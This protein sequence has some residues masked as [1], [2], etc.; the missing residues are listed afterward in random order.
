MGSKNLIVKKLCEVIPSIGFTN[1]YDLFAGG[2]AVSHRMIELN[3]FE[4]Y[5]IND[6]N[7]KA[8]SLFQTALVQGFHKPKY[9]EWVERERF[10]QERETN[11]FIALCWSFGNKEKTYMYSR[12][13]EPFKQSLHYAV[14]YNDYYLLDKYNTNFK[15]IIQQGKTINARRLLLRSKKCEKYFIE[16]Q[17]T[18]YKNSAVDTLRQLGHL[19]RLNR[20]QQIQ[21]K[22]SEYIHISQSSYEKVKIAP[23]S[24]IFC[25]PPYHGTTQYMSNK[26]NAFSHEKFYD[27]VES[28]KELVLITEYSM[29]KDRFVKVWECKKNCSLSSNKNANLRKECLFVPKK[30]LNFYMQYVNKRIF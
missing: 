19:E 4:N 16:L 10:M 27:W 29:P 22:N 21:I 28:Q 8:L 7:V 25:D 15:Y 3:N 24:I 1:F 30:Q 9:Y 18:L 20:L 14:V 17:Q 26:K 12:E 6:I 23:N 11:G 13:L 5:Y 2:C